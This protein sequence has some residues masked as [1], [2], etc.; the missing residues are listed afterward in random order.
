MLDKA[1]V[2][3]CKFLVRPKVALSEMAKTI[4]ANYRLQALNM[5]KTSEALNELSTIMAPFNTRM[6]TGVTPKEV[7]S[8]LKYTIRKDDDE[9][10]KVFDR[11]EHLGHMLYV[12]GS[13]H[14]QLKSLVRNPRDYARK[15]ETASFTRIQGR[16]RDQNPEILVGQPSCC[17]MKNSACMTFA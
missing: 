1:S 2:I 14:K 13:H 12:V 16:P 15:C 11:M 5:P 9:T 6:G 7:H 3:N 17:F 4:T 10:D 8:L